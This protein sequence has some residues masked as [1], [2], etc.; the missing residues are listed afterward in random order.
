MSTGLSLGVVP[1]QLPPTQKAATQKA[2][3]YADRPAELS[4][5]ELSLL[6]DGFRLAFAALGLLCLTGIAVA[7]APRIQSRFGRPAG[8]AFGRLFGRRPPG[9]WAPP[10]RR[11]G[12]PP[13]PSVENAP[14]ASRE[15]P[16][17]SREIER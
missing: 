15:K 5:S 8:R 13:S 11:A 1:A 3:A 6:F 10:P 12:R 9:P 16:R 17:I 14:G 7:L 4:T 2:A